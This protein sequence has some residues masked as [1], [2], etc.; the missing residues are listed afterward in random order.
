MRDS[1]DALLVNYRYFQIRNEKMGELVYR[2]SWVTDKEIGAEKE[3]HLVACGR[4]WWKIEKK[5]NKGLKNRGYNLEH[6]FGHG[7]NHAGEMFCLL[8]WR[9]Q[10]FSGLEQGSIKILID[11]WNY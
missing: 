5:Y 7:K 6:N 3:E 9:R 4:A 8:Q 2:N 11:C 1:P 10:P